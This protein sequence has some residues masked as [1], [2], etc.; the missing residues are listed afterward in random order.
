M[1][2]GNTT[3]DVGHLKIH[4]MED[5]EALVVETFEQADLFGGHNPFDES[6]PYQ[7]DELPSRND[8]DEMTLRDQAEETEQ[9]EITPEDLERPGVLYRLEIGPSTFC[10][11]AFPSENMQKSCDALSEGDEEITK[12]LKLTNLSD[13]EFVLQ[14]Y[15]TEYV[16]LAEV[17]CDQLANQR[18]PIHEEKICNISDPGFSWWLQKAP[19]KIHIL[20]KSYGME[21]LEDSIKLGPLGDSVWAQKKFKEASKALGELFPL[22]EFV[23]TN[24]DLTI[25]SSDPDHPYFQY[26]VELFSK[27][28]EPSDI[29]QVLDGN[30]PS[31]TYCYLTELASVRRFWRE[32]EAQLEAVLGANY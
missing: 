9:E 18:F 27:G 25:G 3:Q 28:K 29:Y 5:I 15:P 14:C 31:E 11:R 22:N 20:F 21:N 19:G 12:K 24:K 32:I 13:E 7:L 10:L 17:I 23:C 30:M 26:L 2:S 6:R 16:E 1:D 4:N 8:L